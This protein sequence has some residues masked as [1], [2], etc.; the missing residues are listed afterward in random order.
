MTTKKK[1]TL[2]TLKAFI[3]KNEK[4]LYIRPIS[5]FDGST[6]GTE[7]VKT[8]QFKPAHEHQTEFAAVCMDHTLGYQG[9]WLVKQSRD[10][11]TQFNENGFTGYHVYNCC[12][13][14]DIAIKEVAAINGDL[15]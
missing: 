11:I 6:D 12:G 4:A 5:A 13:S 9:L 1:P 7:Y 3:R 2:A 10:Y 14:C 15:K 8:P